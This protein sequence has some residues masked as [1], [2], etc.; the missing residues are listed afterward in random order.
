MF[1]VRHCGHADVLVPPAQL[2]SS[3]RPRRPCTPPSQRLLHHS[4]IAAGFIH[5]AHTRACL[6]PLCP[7]SGSYRHAS[8]SSRCILCVH[9]LVCL[10]S[11]YSFVLSLLPASV[12][13]VSPP[14]ALELQYSLFSSLACIPT[15]PEASTDT[16]TLRL[17]TSCFLSARVRLVEFYGST[18]P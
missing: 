16:E 4:P 15:V 2:S 9:D 6:S 8:Q 14:P 11:P 1:A 17:V 7:T 5:R 13:L 3:S 12:M 18:P 10:L